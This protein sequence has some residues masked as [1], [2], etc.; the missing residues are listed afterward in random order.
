MC[1]RSCARAAKRG[2][3]AHRAGFWGV[4]EPGSP[5]LSLHRARRTPLAVEGRG[6]IPTSTSMGGFEARDVGTKV[7]R[8]AEALA[9]LA[10]TRLALNPGIESAACLPD[11][12]HRLA[13]L[14]QSIQPGQPPQTAESAST[15]TPPAQTRE[16]VAANC[17]AL[18][19]PRGRLTP[20]LDPAPLFRYRSLLRRLRRRSRST[21]A[22]VKS[23][24]RRGGWSVTIPPAA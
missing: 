12:R 15:L 6:C 23:G 14:Q 19:W 9:G 18:G 21:T 24:D 20:D 13:R 8:F 2:P 11:Q 3:D 7:S 17:A 22:Q 1:R 16:L 5:A 4:S 10:A